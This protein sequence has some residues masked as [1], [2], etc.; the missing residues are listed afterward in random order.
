MLSPGR[1]S[2]RSIAWGLGLGFS[3]LGIKVVTRLRGNPT[4]AFA[5]SMK[6]NRRSDQTFENDNITKRQ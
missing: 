1:P 6:E 2:R 4:S 5:F 3:F